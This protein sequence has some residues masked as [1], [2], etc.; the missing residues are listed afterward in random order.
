MIYYA[1]V[2]KNTYV[3]ADYA[4]YDG[5]FPIVFQQIINTTPKTNK[6]STYTKGE[7]TYCLRH[8]TDGY[9][10]GC[11][12]NSKAP[13]EVSLKFLELLQAKTYHY[14]ETVSKSSAPHSTA[15]ALTKTIRDLIVISPSSYRKTQ[16][17]SSQ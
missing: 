12:I 9:A 8:N 17:A 5:E 13:Q 7:H 6:I 4:K 14:L 1:V 11:L 3:L 10:F 15:S 16:T 2:A